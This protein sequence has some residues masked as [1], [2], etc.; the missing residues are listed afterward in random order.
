[1]SVTPDELVH[2]IF[3]LQQSQVPDED[4]GDMGIDI[5]DDS[6]AVMIIQSNKIIGIGNFIQD[7]LENVLSSVKDGS[8]LSKRREL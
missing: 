1:M 5:Q 2:T 8:W 3:T 6:C 4:P 7:A